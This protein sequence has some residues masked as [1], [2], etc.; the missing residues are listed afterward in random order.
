MGINVNLLAKLQK[1]LKKRKK[2][3]AE[4]LSMI[5]KILDF[6]ETEIRLYNILLKKELTMEEIVQT[7]NVSERS[8]REHIKMLCEKGFVKRNVVMGNRLKYTYASASPKIAW[9]IVKKETNGALK[10]V[11]EILKK[12]SFPFSSQ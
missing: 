7:L 1:A 10:R 8:A 3:P 12:V 6:K 9:K 2:T 11:D 4:V 5:L